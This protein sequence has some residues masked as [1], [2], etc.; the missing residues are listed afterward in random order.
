MSL[1]PAA[2]VPGTPVPLAP[3][4]PGLE[5]ANAAAAA[6][7]LLDGRFAAGISLNSRVRYV[8]HL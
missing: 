2:T 6:S 4:G 8:G 3:G 1:Q 7:P 5:A